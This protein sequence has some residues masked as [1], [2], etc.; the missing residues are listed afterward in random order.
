MG[1]A[2][3]AVSARTR[4]AGAQPAAR[5]YIELTLFIRFDLER[6]VDKPSLHSVSV[7][8]RRTR[9]REPVSLCLFLWKERDNGQCGSKDK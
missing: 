1:T 3:A 5:L 7:Y 8:P 9:I 4:A 2:R 6:E